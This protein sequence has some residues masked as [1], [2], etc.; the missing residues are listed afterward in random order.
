MPRFVTFEGIEGCGKTTQIQLLSN[1][2]EEKGID[3]L[4]TREPGG[5]TTGD[6]I[7]RLVLDPATVIGPWCELLLYAAARAQHLEQVI[8]PAL[9]EGR[10]VLCDRFTDATRA[11]QGFGRGLPLDIIE[12]LH[13]LGPLALEPD[14]TI[15]IDT[16]PETA[17]ARAAERDRAKTVDESRFEQ[18][19]RAFHDRVRQGYL[20]L[21]R[22]SPGRFVVVDGRGGIAEVRA[23]VAAAFG[24]MV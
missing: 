14:R 16:D 15:L 20:E 17:L 10:L 7:R 4:L 18:E 11:Y 21:A 24:G 22:R 19:N 2:L 12:R 13:A 9:A 8:R 5:T 23:R 1:A 3:H 6:Q